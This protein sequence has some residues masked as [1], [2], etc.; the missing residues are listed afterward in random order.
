LERLAKRRSQNLGPE[1]FL[2]RDEPQRFYAMER[3]LVDYASR[4]FG[5]VVLD[6]SG[7]INISWLENVFRYLPGLGR[8]QANA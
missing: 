6:T 1:D 5:A 8:D 4:H 7:E 2:V 3:Q